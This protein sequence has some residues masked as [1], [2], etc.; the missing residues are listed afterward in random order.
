MGY[1][2]GLAGAGNRPTLLAVTGPRSTRMMEDVRAQSLKAKHSALENQINEEAKR[3]LPDTRLLHDLKRKK[4][5][6][7]DELQKIAV[8]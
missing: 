8:H 4:L 5:K 2:L 6:I 1:G 3:P 7:K